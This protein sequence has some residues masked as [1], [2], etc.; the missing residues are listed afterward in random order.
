MASVDGLGETDIVAGELAQS[1]VAGAH[2]CGAQTQRMDG[3]T[4]V[5]E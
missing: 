4:Q 1:T 3:N 5:R 2:C